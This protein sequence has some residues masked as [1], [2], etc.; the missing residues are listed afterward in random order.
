LDIA[1]DGTSVVGH[2]FSSFDFPIMLGTDQSHFVLAGDQ[3]DQLNLVMSH[4]TYIAVRSKW[5]DVNGSRSVLTQRASLE[6]A[7]DISGKIDAG[8]L[9]TLT[10][11]GVDLPTNGKKYTEIISGQTVPEAEPN[12]YE[13]FPGQVWVTE[14]Q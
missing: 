2:K 1:N 9:Y 14:N 13:L 8:G 4:W 3:V 6:W 10:G 12:L 11:I 5:P 7:M